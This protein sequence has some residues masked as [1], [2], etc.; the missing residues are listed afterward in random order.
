M[1]WV[2]KPSARNSCLRRGHFEVVRQ[3]EEGLVNGN[4]GKKKKGEEYGYVKLRLLHGI[5]DM[6]EN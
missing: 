3:P 2:T 5:L 4:Q 1:P 6:L